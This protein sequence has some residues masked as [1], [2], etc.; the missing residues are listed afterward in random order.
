MGVRLQSKK[1]S[2]DILAKPRTPNAHLKR[3]PGRKKINSCSS[4]TL[5]KA[6]P[7]GQKPTAQARKDAGS[8]C[9]SNS[10]VTAQRAARGAGPAGVSKDACGPSSSSG[11]DKELNSLL[12]QAK[13]SLGR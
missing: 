5:F 7:S 11:S 12:R 9:T 8:R 13:Q 10:D 3:S 4:S 6:R 2:F 1:P